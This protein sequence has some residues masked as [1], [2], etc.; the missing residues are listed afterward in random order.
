[1]VEVVHSTEAIYGLRMG[2]G[3]GS[4]LWAGK[5]VTLNG[6][7]LDTGLDAINAVVC[8][9]VG[10]HAADSTTLTLVEPASVSG[11]IVTFRVAMVLLTEAVDAIRRFAAVTTSGPSVYV[12][13]SGRVV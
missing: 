5:I 2:V 12:I 3:K 6:D 10:R 1:M 13:V 8:S 4:R 9:Q 7:T 11:G